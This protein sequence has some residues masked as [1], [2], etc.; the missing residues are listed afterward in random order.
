MLNIV[1]TSPLLE[2]FMVL[3]ASVMLRVA[4]VLLLSLTELCWPYTKAWS[5]TQF[6]N[7]SVSQTPKTLL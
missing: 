3:E 4:S 6:W 5:W 2:S 7:V 1:F